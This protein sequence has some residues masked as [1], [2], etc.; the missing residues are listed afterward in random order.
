MYVE[1]NSHGTYTKLHSGK[2]LTLS[3]VVGSHGFLCWSRTV[4]DEV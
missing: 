1:M 4:D 3:V 2:L